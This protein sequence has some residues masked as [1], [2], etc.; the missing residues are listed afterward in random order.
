MADLTMRWIVAPGKIE[1][2][3]RVGIVVGSIIK[4]LCTAVWTRTAIAAVA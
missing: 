4:R 3:A 1:W 2:E